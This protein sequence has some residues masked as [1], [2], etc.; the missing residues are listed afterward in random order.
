[1]SRKVRLVEGPPWGFRITGGA[2]VDQNIVVTRVTPG[3]P[4]AKAGLK[5]RDIL[6]A[7]N[8][9][10]LIDSTRQEAEALVRT[11]QHGGLELVLKLATAW[12]AK[13]GRMQATDPTWAELAKQLEQPR[14]VG[15]M[16]AEGG[17]VTQGTKFQSA[18]APPTVAPPEHDVLEPRKFLPKSDDIICNN[19]T[20]PIEGEYSSVEGLNFHK[21]CFTCAAPNCQGSL[22]VGFL[23]ESGKPYCIS[24][25]DK[26]FSAV[27][28]KCKKP[29]FTEAFRALNCQWH[30]ECFTC[31][32]CQ[33]PIYD[34]IFQMEMGQ[35]YCEE[36]H[37]RLFAAMCCACGKLIGPGDKELK[38][39]DQ[40]WHHRCFNCQKCHRNLDGKRFVRRNNM[41][42]C[43]NCK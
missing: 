25:H 20:Q 2:D 4:A 41:P 43:H 13:P 31:T 7:I 42:C 24:C 35:V 37:K 3:S 1:M 12:D 9:A 17:L 27:C 36:D 6:L 21:S 14:P 30:L 38:A 28:L 26:Y 29:I 39:I 16:R 18:D 10:L 11:S 15:Q 40:K 8:G 19:C 32:A 33:K 5:S 22:D 23:V 34:G